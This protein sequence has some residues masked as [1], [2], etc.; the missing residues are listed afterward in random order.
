MYGPIVDEQRVFQVGEGFAGAGDDAAHVNTVLGS[1]DGPVGTAW[2]TALASP[3]EGHVPFVAV[4]RPN[5]PVQ[6]PT[7][8]V[9]KATLAGPEHERLTWGAAQAGVAAGVALAVRDGAVTAAMVGDVVVIAAV[10]VAPSARDA[11]M[12]F[13]NNRDA[14]RAALGMGSR[15]GPVAD[16]VAAASEQPENPFYP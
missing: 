7:L 6:P 9:N 1:R 13:A 12:V 8:F 15:G 11:S 10:W 3:S 4:A 5:V 14:T 2:A 16:E